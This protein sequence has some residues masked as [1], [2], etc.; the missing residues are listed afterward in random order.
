MVDTH[1]HLT[2]KDFN[3]DREKIVSHFDEDGI[4]FVVEVGYNLESSKRAVEFALSH[5]KIY[6]AIG[7][8]P[9]DVKALHGDWI[10]MLRMFSKEQKVVAIGEIGLDY[11]RDLSPRFV[12][13]ESFEKQLELAESL[14]LPVIFH[15]RDAYPDAREIIR[16]HKVRGV[17]HS[18][19]GTLE[20][21]KDFLDMGLYIG[22]GGIATYEKNDTLRKIISEIPVD[23]VLIETDSPYLFPRMLER[24]D[25][26]GLPAPR[27]LE[28]R[29]PSEHITFKTV[30]GRRNEPKY[31]RFVLDLLSTL[32]AIPLENMEKI[33][34]QNAKNLFNLS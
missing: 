34:T 25:S 16:K 8:H 27:M 12:Q 13:K 7:V 28:R 3:K 32:F 31:V 17:V 15:I 14:N 2:M 4:E 11:Y 26:Q 21:V 10:S 24:R 19:N 23:R 20:D 9:H 5:S 18:F 22:I 29:V 30:R 1:V 33:T 6:S